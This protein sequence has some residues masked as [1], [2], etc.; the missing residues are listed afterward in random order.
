MRVNVADRIR[1]AASYNAIKELIIC[2]VV[3]GLILLWMWWW[4]N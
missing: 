4:F 1:E 3:A 2:M